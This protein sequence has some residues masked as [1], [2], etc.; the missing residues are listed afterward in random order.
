M[1]QLAAV[2]DVQVV[3]LQA[4]G[5]ARPNVGQ[6]N[7]DRF[8]ASRNR[9]ALAHVFRA[10]VIQLDESVPGQ[11]Q[12]K[13]ENRTTDDLEWLVG[14]EARTGGNNIARCALYLSPS[15]SVFNSPCLSTL[16]LDQERAEICVAKIE[17]EIQIQVF[18]NV[19]WIIV[20]L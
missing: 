1:I 10:P 20:C 5:H 2:A 17:T 15:L 13:K 12:E 18:E 7:N 19:A 8:D 6:I 16:A 9:A 3:P 4:S 14:N 11:T